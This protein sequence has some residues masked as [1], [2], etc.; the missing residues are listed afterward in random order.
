MDVFTEPKQGDRVVD[1][2]TGDEYL[3]EAY[4][5]YTDS[6]TLVN[7]WTSVSLSSKDFYANF[8][9]R[10][11]L[12]IGTENKVLSLDKDLCDHEYTEYQGLRES[13]KFCKKCDKK[14]EAP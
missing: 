4:D 10:V 7:W 14:L 3:Y 2:R 8:E 11:D 6:V 12:P 1:T 5:L 13:F 9:F